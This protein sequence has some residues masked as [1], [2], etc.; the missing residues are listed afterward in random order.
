MLVDE[1]STLQEI[2]QLDHQLITHCED[3]GT[4][5]ANL[6]AAKEKYGDDIPMSMHPLI[7]SEEACYLSSSA[8]VEL[9]KKYDSRLHV[10]HISTAK[11]L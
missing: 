3:E 4:I 7:R 10:F 6:K 2:F 8:A 9:A 11:E 5:Q 1:R